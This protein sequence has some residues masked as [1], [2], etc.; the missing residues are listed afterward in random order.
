MNSNLVTSQWKFIFVPS[1]PRVPTRVFKKRLYT[2][3]KRSLVDFFLH[4]LIEKYLFF[5]MYVF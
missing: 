2:N 5:I 4:Y 3:D 1:Y